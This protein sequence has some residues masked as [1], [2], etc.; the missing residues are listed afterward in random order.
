M[1]CSTL[2]FNTFPPLFLS[3]LLILPF[4]RLPFFYNK[5]KLV[6]PSLNSL[7]MQPDVNSNNSEEL[8]K[9][10][11]ETLTPTLNKQ[12]QGKTRVEHSHWSR[13]L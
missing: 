11:E 12:Y 6:S 4:Y 13:D 8:V 1:L 2:F 7:C 9:S 10:S 3:L 5:M